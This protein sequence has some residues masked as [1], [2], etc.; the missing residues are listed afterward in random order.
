MIFYFLLNFCFFENDFKI[1]QN[2]FVSVLDALRSCVLNFLAY[3]L[4]DLFIS[5]LHSRPHFVSN[6]LFS[7]NFFRLY[8]LRLILNC[9]LFSYQL[10][11]YHGLSGFIFLRI[12][13]LV[14]KIK[15]ALFLKI[16]PILLTTLFTISFA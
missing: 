13:V 2:F 8:F 4:L 16:S 3:S 7:D 6:C 14:P 1:F 11:V 9:F 10:F 12:V 5:F 15:V